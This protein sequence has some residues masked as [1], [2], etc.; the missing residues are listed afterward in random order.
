[1]MRR[2]NPKWRDSDYSDIDL[3]N[4]RGVAWLCDPI[5]WMNYKTENSSFA[6][7]S[8]SV[9]MLI[10]A[11]NL[12]KTGNENADILGCIV[13]SANGYSLLNN[14]SSTVAAQ[15]APGPN[16]VFNNSSDKKTWLCSP[17]SGDSESILYDRYGLYVE[18]A[19]RYTILW[20]SPVVP[21]DL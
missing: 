15:I 3:P 2:M 9:E 16:G 18:S 4:E 14:G 1:M 19:S 7:G 8:P 12:W 11:F 5:N 6:I 10:K 21:I 20:Y 13:D 17:S